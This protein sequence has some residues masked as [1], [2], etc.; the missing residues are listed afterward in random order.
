M[1]KLSVR[2]S[3]FLL[4]IAMIL[5]LLPVSVFAA[6][7]V[8]GSSGTQP[9]SEGDLTIP[10]YTRVTSMPAEGLSGEYLIV[11]PYTH[12]DT[13]DYYMLYPGATGGIV[14]NTGVDNSALLTVN[15]DGVATGYK[16]GHNNTYASAEEKTD[17][18]AAENLISIS[19]SSNTPPIYSVTASGPSNADYYLFNGTN[20]IYHNSG[21]STLTIED[22]STSGYFYLRNRANN[23]AYLIFYA[24]QMDFAQSGG[25]P[26]NRDLML[27]QKDSE[28]KLPGYNQVTS[29]SQIKADRNYLIV[30]QAPDETFYALHINAD[31]AS[32]RPGATAYPNCAATLTV[33]GETVCAVSTANTD[34]SIAMNDL[35]VTIA[36]N[37]S[38]YTIKNA[39]H[40]LA[41]V[42]NEMYH[43]SSEDIPLE[44]SFVADSRFNIRNRTY[45]RYLTFNVNG[46]ATDETHF[47]NLP[48]GFCGW[49][50]PQ[51]NY[52]PIYLYIE[53]DLPAAEVTPGSALAGMLT[54]DQI[55]GANGSADPAGQNSWVFTGGRAAQGSYAD[56]AGARSWA[57]HFEEWVR[58][59]NAKTIPASGESVNPG[60]QRHVINAA[61][62]GQ[63]LKNIVDSF[64]T[65]IAA[66]KPR[67]VVYLV[68]EGGSSAANFTTDL[69]SLIEKALALKGGTGMIVIGTLT[70][71]DK[72]A[73]DEVV[74]NLAEGN[75]SRVLPVLFTLTDTQKTGGFPNAQGHMEMAKKLA[76]AVAG[77]TVSSS[78]N[79]PYGS[80]GTLDANFPAKTT[81]TANHGE[82]FKAP[83]SP[84]AA[85]T[86]IK[87]K[88]V[89]TENAMTW[90]F[91]GDSITH[92]AAWTGGYDSL[93]QLFEKFVK[94]DLNRPQDIV[95]NAGSS[96]A[97]TA[98]TITDLDRRLTKYSPDVVVLM[99][100][101]NDA[102]QG[103]QVDTYKAN[104]GTL[105]D[106]ILEKDAVAVL[107]TQPPANGYSGFDAYT[108]AAKEVAGASKY[109]GKVIVVDQYAAWTGSNWNDV[110]TDNN[111]HPD[112]A[113][114][115]WFVHQLIN[116]M[117]LWDDD[118]EVCKL[119]YVAR[120]EQTPDQELLI[121]GYTRVMDLPEDGLDAGYYLFV[122]KY[123]N[124]YY[125]I[126]P[127]ATGG[128][129]NVNNAAKLVMSEN[130]AT[131]YRTKSAG[132]D[133]GTV[134][135]DWA[136]ANNL[137]T[138]RGDENDR[139]K[140][141]SAV[142]TG[143][144]NTAY[145]LCKKDTTGGGGA[146]YQTN[147]ESAFTIHA[148]GEAGFFHLRHQAGAGSYL[149]FY[150]AHM[151]FNQ[152][153]TSSASTHVGNFL[154]F[155]SNTNPPAPLSD[156]EE[157]IATARAK[158]QSDYTAGSWAAL[159][160][161]LTAAEAV[162]ADEAQ[163]ADYQAVTD[164][165]KAL[166]AAVNGLQEKPRYQDPPAGATVKE[167]ETLRPANG[168]TTGQPFPSENGGIAGGNHY[169]IPGIA[170]VKGGDH[171][172]RLV[173]VTDMRW[174]N[175]RDA[176]NIDTVVSYS[177]DNGATW[178]YSFANYFGDS[179]DSSE[180][181]KTAIFIDPVITAGN[182]GSLYMMVNAFPAGTAT[183]PYVD[184]GQ[185][186]AATGFVDIP[187]GNGNG[188]E[189]RLAIYTTYVKNDQTDD[190]YAYYLGDFSNGYA[191]ILDAQGGLAS[192][193]YV[194]AHYYLYYQKGAQKNPATDKIYCQQLD[195]S[196]VWIQQNLFF[197]NA[198]LHV[199][200]VQFLYMVK[201][202]DG[203]ETWG[204]PMLLNGQVRTG[205]HIFYGPGP[206][207][208]I[209]M[210]DGTLIVPMYAFTERSSFI[211]SNDNGATWHR[212]PV[213]GWESTENTIVQ[214]GPNTLRQ[215]Y[216]SR[217]HD[218][219]Y[220][221]YTRDGNGN[222][223]A[224]TEVVR[225]DVKKQG[226]NQVSAL[227]YST[228]I[229]GK[230]VILF[231]SASNT[232][233]A[234]SGYARKGGHIYAFELKSDGTLNVLS[235]YQYSPTT[236]WYGYSSLTELKNGAVGLIYEDSQTDGNDP[237]NKGY[238]GLTYVTLPI[239][240]IVYGA[241]LNNKLREAK[242]LTQGNNSDTSWDAFQAA[243]A[244]A[245][246]VL[247]KVDNTKAEIE[248]A[249][250]ALTAAQSGLKSNPTS[251]TLNHTT[252]SLFTN[253]AGGATT[254]QLTATVTPSNADQTIT[255]SSTNE[256][257][258][259][260]N[261]T[262]LVTAVGNGTALI[263]AQSA[264]QGVFASCTVTVSTRI[265]RITVRKDG[266]AV[267]SEPIKL[268]TNANDE[269]HSVTLTAETVPAE[270]THPQLDWTRPDGAKGQLTF[271][272]RGENGRSITVTAVPGEKN[273]GEVTV[274]VAS[275]DHAD[276]YT[277]FKIHVIR[278]LENNV[279]I[280]I[281][282]VNDP[283]KAPQYG[284]TLEADINDLQM[285]DEGKDALTYQ[286]KRTKNGETTN[287]GTG[288][289]TYTLTQED[290]GAVISVDVTAGVNSFYEG[291]RSATRRQT[292]EKADGPLTG[293][294][295]LSGTAPSATGL[296]D[297]TITGFDS[298]YSS[299]EYRLIVV[300]GVENEWAAVPSQT[301]SG[302]AAGTYQVR[303]KE[304]S[305]H[306]AGGFSVVTVPPY[307]V[308][309]YAVSLDTM[310]NGRVSRSD[311]AAAEGTV[312]TLTV[313]PETGY[314]LT[315]EGL[316][317][318]KSDGSKV[319]VTKVAGKENEYTFTMP[320]EGVTVKAAF[321]QL[322]FTITH[323]L[324]HLRCSRGSADG[325][326]VA[327][328][329]S[330]AI[331]LV[332]DEGYALPL[333]KD[334]TITNSRGVQITGWTIND[335][336]VITITGGVTSDLVIVAV[337]RAATHTVNYTLTNGLSAPEDN[338]PRS[339]DH[340]A[341]YTGVLEAAEGY[342]LP[343]TVI[344][345]VGGSLIGAENYLYNKDTG[346]ISISVG[347]ISDNVVITAVGVEIGDEVV[348]VTGVTLDRTNA[349][350][351]VGDTLNLIATVAPAN[352]TTKNVVWST[353]DSGIATADENGKV[354]GVA[355]GVT[356]ITVMTLDGRHS[357][358]CTVT[359]SKVS[360]PVTGVSLNRD[361]V[362][363]KVN[364]T[365]TLIATVEPADADDKRVIW[366]SSDTGV[367]TVDENGVVTA[368]SAGEAVITVTTVDGTFT[369]SC[370]V[371]V[372][373]DTTIIA[374]PKSDSSTTTTTNPD[375]STTTTV[376][377]PKTGTVTKTTKNPDG[378]T[379][380]VETK[381]DGTVTTTVTDSEGG[382]VETVT[383]PEKA[384]T[385]TVTDK[386]GETLA[387]LEI[388]AAIPELDA[389]KKFIDVPDN[390]YAADAINNMAALGI[391]NGVG[392][393][394]FN[395]NGYMKRGDL[396]LILSR[397]SH[398]GEGYELSFTD[399]PAT[400]YYANGVAWA[401]K[402][403]VVT[404]YSA[405]EFGPDDTITR[406]QMAVM[407]YRFA[408][409]LGMD[410]ATDTGALGMFDD[411][412]FAH[413]WA[414]EGMSWCIE[415]GILQG[416]GNMTL[417]PNATATRAEVAVM[418]S[419]LME[420]MR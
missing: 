109:A 64:D 49:S 336:G 133:N 246:A 335:K 250:A 310:T 414:A 156:L 298:G 181:G 251:V 75:Q 98:S 365:V 61:Y 305:T 229:D 63:T 28:S 209:C 370:G 271:S 141:Y 362:D 318:E 363:L 278:K 191:D 76:N 326:Q 344:V 147:C 188:T 124:D 31:G 77:G 92:G 213:L 385:I 330:T 65:R 196:N 403:G 30:A 83:D 265:E 131:G 179:V 346:E 323:E 43:A 157:L 273:V 299:Y 34:T 224:G 208:G 26:D 322:T 82:N 5:S 19:D 114:H 249:L 398:G 366:S 392:G 78:S 207:A 267:G 274:R 29:L 411:G 198:T 319:N 135:T 184:Q 101:T 416:K 182:D 13:T 152:M 178:H 307:N 296:S 129:Q 170:T 153:G 113:G 368:V 4:S 391:V 168:T 328:G 372:R 382:K 420:Q 287:I 288:S 87:N 7:A 146:L 144:N 349:S 338:A 177:D 327:Y 295:G 175:Y 104:L 264:K 69:N 257:V 189:K 173:A 150:I 194:D 356:V 244:S 238:T 176:Y 325:H 408:G 16:V 240:T 59:T 186:A 342:A 277:E 9:Q 128:G 258:A 167:L 185:P 96:G 95:I 166:R 115:L 412:V 158:T 47:P 45:N 406:E 14:N 279:S 199:R 200:T 151:N 99:L 132:Y 206:G 275:A 53:G 218:L 357:A 269:G 313:L 367:A 197:Q 56:I 169:R 358:S 48:T 415:R 409:L 234:A 123:G 36:A 217:S 220:V 21:P 400:K 397:I 255:W 352:A 143:P 112:E 407:L 51:P 41:L 268:Y 292:V 219:R 89:N 354:T 165:L 380:V 50:D 259:T 139:G 57:G 103:I 285:T 248:E 108:A 66:Q 81:V 272:N 10:G 79:W 222:W 52:I 17:F 419:R 15:A 37:D 262:G 74:K 297:G 334:I 395:C 241:K 364:G 6:E 286:W 228:Q 260:V 24:T 73:V 311:S 324:T 401:A 116:E 351:T 164:A 374:P 247:A 8:D 405:T 102:I 42:Q 256:A 303:A 236:E 39:T 320:A 60:F 136:A 193:Y 226:N 237:N 162:V 340:L 386:D 379:E 58:Y 331:T 214:I 263:T 317:V 210:T 350:I 253:A 302:L 126:Y 38:N 227:G 387:K 216:R 121:D 67:A 85:Q 142:A 134:S 106:A 333:R 404:G 54:G 1:K 316:S 107:R 32:N 309:V 393:Q 172:G 245:E 192:G 312:V 345:T 399:V 337:G 23:Q 308:T 266:V 384:V 369:A 22:S 304:T 187:T 282:G 171:D 100:G 94:D 321:E 306:K 18:S 230:T 294:Q 293:P 138:L 215:F 160:T 154:L 343:E 402:T 91:M 203:G 161:A 315:A 20:Q 111:L 339:A 281:Q 120:R 231:S 148:A 11:A 62:T 130:R 280:S 155:K 163:K 122:L 110:F 361:S 127:G 211:Y 373:A 201:S 149:I 35:H 125:M 12:D 371:T 410:T 3:C 235:S 27:F 232:S 239:N 119:E 118:A 301:I 254:L 290:V 243:I 46:A 145:Y 233:I 332:P 341:A 418:L 355:E 377:D 289:K 389:G 270:V 383:T 174:N 137:L 378:S 359:V 105:L 284:Q 159:S 242:S 180:S 360:Q 86:A 329:E 88:V 205:E 283:T 55:G 376:T 381:K 300:D 72:T 223:T 347:R 202:T 394:M 33:S 97:T 276:V 71:A 348:S 396:A 261:G 44:L 190:N 25:T 93:S 417:A 68:D 291:T 252:A 225:P 314:Q 117:G 80:I 195:A 388:P 221:D 204:D 90:L 375:G 212:G 390:H 183:W 140:L 84:T 353:E 2:L 413:D 70:Q 40:C